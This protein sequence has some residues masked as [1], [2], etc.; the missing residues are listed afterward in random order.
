MHCHILAVGHKMPEW[1]ELA[2]HD[3]LTRLQRFIKCTLSEIPTTLRSKTKSALHCKEDE[4][5]KILRKISPQD[6][7]IALD[8]QGQSWST[9]RLAKNFSDWQLE[10]KNLF[11][12]IGGPDGLSE[13]CLARANQKWSLSDLTFPHALVRVLLLEQLYRAN[14]MLMNHPYHRE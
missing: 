3:Y 7:L 11:F 8:I 5:L 1:C 4:G 2:C 12:V 9:A 13:K 14:S 10:G 6:H